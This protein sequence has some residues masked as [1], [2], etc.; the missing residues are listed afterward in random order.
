MT[1]G[2]HEAIPVVLAPSGTPVRAVDTIDEKLADS[3][4][5][6]RRLRDSYG[7]A[8]VART[9]LQFAADPRRARRARMRSW[10]RWILR[11][12]Q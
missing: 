9:T 3:T 4:A 12:F 6:C 7:R 11:L 10:V 8:E 5:A 1:T 2:V